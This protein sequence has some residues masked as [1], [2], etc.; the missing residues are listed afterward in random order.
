MH[1][2]EHYNTSWMVANIG[3]KQLMVMGCNVESYSDLD[4]KCSTVG[5]IPYMYI[6]GVNGSPPPA[7][8]VVGLI[9]NRRGWTYCK[10][11]IAPWNGDPV[12][13]YHKWLN[14]KGKG[15]SF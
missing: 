15:S 12:G 7:Y 13:A 11:P 10:W 2:H 5:S 8:P 14:F 3:H 6:T 1:F 9:T 4:V